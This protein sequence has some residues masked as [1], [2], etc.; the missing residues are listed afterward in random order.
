MMRSGRARKEDVVVVITITRGAALFSPSF[1]PADSFDEKVS[2]KPSQGK[3]RSLSVIPPRHR[4]VTL[5][6]HGGLQLTQV[7]YD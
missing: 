3:E 1:L 5:S 4:S 6:L 7:T 2:T